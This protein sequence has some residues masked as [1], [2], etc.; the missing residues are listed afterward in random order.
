MTDNREDF[1]AS[2]NTIST[3]S[4]CVCVFYSP[5]A[6]VGKQSLSGGPVIPANRLKI[7]DEEFLDGLLKPCSHY[8]ILIARSPTAFC[9]L[10]P[11]QDEARM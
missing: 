1:T 8:A 7:L 4:W 5:L 6:A 3:V 10:P 9:S 2:I 11:N